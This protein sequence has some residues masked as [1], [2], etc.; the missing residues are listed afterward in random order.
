MTNPR[1][2]RSKAIG[3]RRAWELAEEYGI[4]LTVLRPGPILGSRDPKLTSRY[5]RAFDRRVVAVPTFR[6]PHVH[7]G[8][9]A[10]A[11]GGALRN[12]DSAGRAYNVTGDSISPWE[13]LRAWKRRLGR[14]PLM[15]PIFLP[16]W[17][18]YDDT[19]AAR[20]LG[21]RSRSLDETLEEIMAAGS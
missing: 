13:V 6:I 8:D 11:V 4:G 9:V 20:D 16:V 18:D 17:I 5:A 7:A 3:E 1:Y 14:G 12:P 10:F 15:V 2:G 21:F 19:A